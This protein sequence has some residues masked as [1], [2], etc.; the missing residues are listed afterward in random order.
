MAGQQFT[1]GDS[2][3][4]DIPDENDIDHAYHGRHGDVIDILTDDLHRLT[5]NPQDKYLY[6]IQFSDNT[7]LDCRQRDLRPPIE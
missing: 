7:T 1:E 2:V 4:I 3:R 5:G 6:T